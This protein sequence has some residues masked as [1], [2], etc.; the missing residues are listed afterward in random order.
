MEYTVYHFADEEAAMEKHGYPEISSHREEHNDLALKVKFFHKA[1]QDGQVQIT[2]NLVG[3][4]K[5]WVEKH[6]KETD[7]RY[8]P[9]LKDKGML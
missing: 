8:A 3:M 2:K 5:N 4:L 1:F 7:R 9:F 6:I